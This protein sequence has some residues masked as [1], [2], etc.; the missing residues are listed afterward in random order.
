MNGASEVTFIVGTGR[1]GSTM[2]SRILHVHP[3]VLSL[4]EFFTSLRGALP[5]QEV[6]TGDVDGSEL[7]D[8]LSSPDPL[9]DAV[10]RDGL[11]IPE[12]SYPYGR[13][14]FSPDTGVPKICHSTLPV[15]TDHPDALY[16]R[17]AAEVPGWPRRTAADS[18]RA[19]FRFLAEVLGRRVVVER[20]GGSLGVIPLL[21]E[22]FP[23]ARFVLMYRDGPDCAL[24][25]S[26]HPIFRFRGLARAAAVEGGLPWPSPLEAIM[27]SMPGHF[28]GLLTPPFDPDRF[29]A[30]PIPLG[31]FGAW[32]STA[33]CDGVEA[34]G[35]VPPGSRAC[36]TYEGLLREPGAELTRL[37][38]FLGVTPLAE[39]LTSAS[40]LVDQRRAGTARRQ[41]GPEDFSQLQEACAL[42]AEAIHSI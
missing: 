41:L 39:W 21:R 30:Y 17:L 28:A 2:L 13:G 32:W 5:G 18:Y 42:G 9:Y 4:S 20:S 36:L 11:R 38:G 37:A 3:D 31:W 7:W 8:I 25:M 29:M 10:V 40:R 15:L 34:L 12:M 35:E 14:R 23:E 22:V 19:L 6:Q 33:M 24:S 16:D 27:A 26:R 1:C